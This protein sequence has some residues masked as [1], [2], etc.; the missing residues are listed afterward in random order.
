M[1]RKEKLV[2]LTSL[3]LIGATAVIVVTRLWSR[4]MTAQQVATRVED[5]FYRQDSGCI[6][7]YIDPLEK[8]HLELNERKIRAIFDMQKREKGR[9]WE[10]SGDATWEEAS[11]AITLSQVYATGEGQSV[12]LGFSIGLTRE[13][14]RMVGGVSTLVLGP[15]ISLRVP[16]GPARVAGVEKIK[17]L[18]AATKIGQVEL[19]PKG[20]KGVYSPEQSDVPVRTWSVMQ[21]NCE[22]IIARSALVAGT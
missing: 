6:L 13:G 17:R 12:R 16:G 7:Q 4:P 8:K 9:A 20:L 21:K 19:E 15:I 10:R 5:C 22:A 14:Y 18:L 1:S 3:A 11:N 2:L